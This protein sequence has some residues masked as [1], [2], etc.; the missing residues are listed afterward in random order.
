MLLK[1]ISMALLTIDTDGIVEDATGDLSSSGLTLILTK[2]PAGHAQQM[3]FVS[4]GDISS[5]NFAV[6]GKDADG[7]DQSETVTGVTTSPVETTK[8]YSEI[9]SITP[10]ATIGAATLD[11]GFVDEMVSETIMLDP[12]LPFYIR[13]DETG[14]L[15]TDVQLLMED[16][17]LS[18]DQESM[19]WNLYDSQLDDILDTERF[20][21]GPGYTAARIK[22]NSFT[23]G[24]TIVA[25]IVQGGVQLPRP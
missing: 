10:D 19:G 3:A 1:K 2:P 21:I 5:V 25:R 12:E 11:V 17:G 7:R 13:Y 22:V 24:A 14:T 16:P 6:V 18:V 23:A 8:Y 4:S 9:T 15:E 20:A